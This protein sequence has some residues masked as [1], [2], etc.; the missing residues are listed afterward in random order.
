MVSKETTIV[1]DLG[2]DMVPAGIL[3][4]T[5]AQYECDVNIVVDGKSFNAKS[6]MNIIAGCIKKGDKVTV[7]ADGVNEQEALDK[8][9]ALIESGFNE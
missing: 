6:V 9:I 8:A 4:R 7:V 3:A 5:V 2:L 1:N